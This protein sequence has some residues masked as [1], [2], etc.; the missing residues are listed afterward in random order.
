MLSFTVQDAWIASL[1]L[2]EIWIYLGCF[3]ANTCSDSKIA[4]FFKLFFSSF[5]IWQRSQKLGPP[6]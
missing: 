5:F 6:G 1:S 2:T 3:K 4:T